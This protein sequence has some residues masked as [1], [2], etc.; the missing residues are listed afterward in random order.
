MSVTVTI[1]SNKLPPMPAHLNA[2]VKDITKKALFDVVAIADPMT[3]VDTNHLR[4]AKEIT[5][6]SVHWLAYYAAYQNNGTVYIA[7]KL[8]ATTGAERVK[9]QWIRALSQIEGRL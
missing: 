7:P 9:P 3:P 2:A 8:F 5:E 6:T 4:S 1:T